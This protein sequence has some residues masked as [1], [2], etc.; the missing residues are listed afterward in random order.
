MVINGF[1]EANN[2]LNFINMFG[3]LGVV[4]SFLAIFIINLV[5]YYF[6]YRYTK[7]HNHQIAGVLWFMLLFLALM[8]LIIGIQNLRLL[9]W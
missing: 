2:A 1:Y 9:T 4:L 6:S 7:K 8:R 3:R 5:I